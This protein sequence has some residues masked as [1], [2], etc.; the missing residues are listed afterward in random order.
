M[1]IEQSV[2]N[3]DVDGSGHKARRARS[4]GKLEATRS[5]FSPRASRGR[6]TASTP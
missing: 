5:G 3:A 2:E 4:H 6:V 1:E